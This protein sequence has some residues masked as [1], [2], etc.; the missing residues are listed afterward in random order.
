MRLTVF[1][2]IAFALSGCVHTQPEHL[3][4][5]EGRATVNARADGRAATLH[6][7]GQSRRSVRSLH[8]GPDETTWVDRLSGQP[9]SAPTTEIV[10]V[11]FRR[12]RNVVRSV[13]IGTG[14]GVIAGA[15]ASTADNRSDAFLAPVILGPE[16]IIASFGIT[17]ALIGTGVGTMQ[18][19]RFL[20]TEPLEA[21]T[22]A[23]P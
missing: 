19:D 14:V 16:V 5:A 7:R 17:G 1:L 21:D 3:G 15:I 8:I 20:V 18:T 23:A 22:L 4:S 11:S 9:E 13:L 6:V 2:A 12:G 10:S